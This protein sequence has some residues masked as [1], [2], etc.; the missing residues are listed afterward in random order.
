MGGLELQRR[1]FS[2]ANPALTSENP[3]LSV[4]KP[5]QQLQRT[6]SPSGGQTRRRGPSTHGEVGPWPLSGI[7][8][9]HPLLAGF[10]D[11]DSRKPRPGTLSVTVRKSIDSRRSAAASAPYGHCG[12]VLRDVSVTARACSVDW[13]EA[14]AAEEQPAFGLHGRNLLPRVPIA[15]N[16]SSARFCLISCPHLRSG[17]SA[18]NV[19]CS[20][21]PAG[22]PGTSCAA[23]GERSPPAPASCSN[24]TGFLGHRFP[25]R[26]QAM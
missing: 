2:E 22:D 5:G 4:E 6:G 13:L 24:P 21:S 23:A 18:S 9:L 14:R 20:R 26:R 11:R 8:W 15:G 10:G 16:G 7:P 3:K 19:G 17:H 12:T 25:R 1:P